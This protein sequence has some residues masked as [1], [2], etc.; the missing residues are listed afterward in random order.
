MIY[1]KFKYIFPPRPKNK[2]HPDF[3]KDYSNG[4]Y[5]AQPKLNGSNCLIFTNGEKVHI[6]NRHN[7][8][9]SRFEI[10]NIKN[11]HVGEKNSWIVLNGEY[12][13]KNK[14]DENNKSFNHKFVIFDILVY[15]NEY[16]LG[17]TFQQRIEIL[18]QI[19]GEKEFDKYLYKITDNIYRVKSF[20]EN[21]DE[22]YSDL[23]AIDMYEGL[24][25]KRING[26]LKNGRTA[27][28]NHNSQLKVRKPTKNYSF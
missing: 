22:I 21:I 26:K 20:K 27:M 8:R 1:S 11:L 7:Q 17:S 12:M 24:V 28:N 2:I 9:M 3:I 25:I 5:L 13:N 16:L 15:N 18:N 6:M 4:R 19:Y 14:K 23:I 10:E